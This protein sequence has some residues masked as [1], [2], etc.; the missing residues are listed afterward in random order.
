MKTI[1]SETQDIGDDLEITKVTRQ[2]AGAGT[3]VCGRLNG[4]GFE[5]LVFT[6]HA[7]NPEWEL[8]DSRISKLWVHRLADQRVVYNWDRGLDVEADVTTQG[9]VDFLAAGLADFVFRA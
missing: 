2:T 9:V 8:E 4:Y 6:E 3:W 5:A 7:D 1:P